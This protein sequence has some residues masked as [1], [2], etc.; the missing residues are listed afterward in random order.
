MRTEIVDPGIPELQGEQGRTRFY[1]R[2]FSNKI[3]MESSGLFKARPAI[4]IPMEAGR[5]APW[6]VS[7]A[8][9]HI[10]SSFH[11][12]SGLHDLCA[13]QAALRRPAQRHRPPG[14]GAKEGAR[15]A[16][17]PSIPHLIA[18]RRTCDPAPSRRGRPR[19]AYSKAG[20]T[21]KRR[22]HEAAPSKNRFRALYALAARG[23][24]AR[25]PFGKIG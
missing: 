2:N 12:G 6:R 5:R 21:R 23:P 16:D 1:A 25:I 24:N 19:P 14:R 18:R 7:D 9:Q 20:Q 3:L 17:A 11:L 8:V 10:C 22:R 15:R 4:L 13:L